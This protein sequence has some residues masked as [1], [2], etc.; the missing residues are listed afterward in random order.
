MYDGVWR[1]NN[2]KQG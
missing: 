2:C 1:S